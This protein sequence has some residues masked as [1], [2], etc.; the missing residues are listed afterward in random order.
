MHIP[1]LKKEVLEY[2]DPKENENFI[3]CTVGHGGH[4]KSILERTSPAGKVLGIDS[5]SKQIEI[6]RSQLKEFKE[7]IILVSSSYT[8]IKEIVGKNKFKADG[9]LLDLGMS[10]WHLENSE[11]G[12]SFLKDE[13]LDMRYDAEAN[14]L[15]AEE[16][17]NSW[18]Q[19]EIETILKGYGEE[20]SAKEISQKIIEE[21]KKRLIKTTFQLVEVIR[22]AV[23]FQH[24]R[25]HFATKTFQA[26]R[27]AVNGELDNLKEV[28]PKAVDVLE[29]NGRIVIISFHS[30]EDKIVKSFLKE[31]VKEGELKIL[32][33]KPIA[34]SFEEIKTNPRSRSA[35]LRAAIKIK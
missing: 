15:T 12:F 28:L 30:L 16:I 31:K 18:S 6:C 29:K 7:R 13:P 19:K 1:V 27:I 25:I 9:V 21:R 32:T 8:K 5:D 4:A 3:D 10:S 14:N 22:K 34:P 17:I 20:R 26:L 11:R 2:L 24:E 33:K 35:K 23:P